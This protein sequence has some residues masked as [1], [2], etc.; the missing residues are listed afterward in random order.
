[1]FLDFVPTWAT[2]SNSN[3]TNNSNSSQADSNPSGGSSGGVNK[4][5]RNFVTVFKI[6]HVFSRS[7]SSKIFGYFQFFLYFF[8]DF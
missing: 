1:M 4:L 8:T 3:G 6:I 2:A 5:Q 7:F